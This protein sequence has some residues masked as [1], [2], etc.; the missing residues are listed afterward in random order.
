MIDYFKELG[1]EMDAY[2]DKVKNAYFNMTKKYPPEKYPDRYRV[3]RDAYETLIDNSKRDEYVLEIFDTRFKEI[4]NAGLD[5]AKSE[6][7]DL[8]IAN[9]EKVLEKYPEN[10]KVKKDLALCLMREK[11]YKRSSKVL[12]ELVLREPNNIEYYKLLM[13]SYLEG[14]EVKKLENVLIKGIRLKNAEVD[15]YLK[16]FDIYTDSEYRDYLKA[17]EILKD[18]IGNK[19]I[20]SQRYK[21]YLKL[22][23]IS[24]KLDCK[25]DFT[26][27]CSL[28]SQL[29]LSNDNYEDV[30]VKITELCYRILKEF[31]F[32]NGIKLTTT[33]LTLIDE[34]K[35]EIVLNE[36]IS[37]RRLFIELYELEYD[38]T[39][40]NDFKRPLY[41]S[42]INKF[43]GDD[44]EIREGFKKVY[45]NFLVSIDHDK[46]NLLDSIT[47]LK[48]NHKEIYGITK[49]FCND[50]LSVYSKA[51]KMESRTESIKGK[52]FGRREESKVK[53][54]IKK[55]LK[56][57]VD[58]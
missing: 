21:L 15:F 47:N 11:D 39:I 30:K 16:L 9:F 5:L 45:S 58:K 14:N 33:A 55:V 28:I 36:I 4:L 24:D 13:T 54:L 53:S 8:A 27:T 25:N 17:I 43:L 42:V 22:I 35:D 12:K 51:K 41:Y 10:I 57:I 50:I 52:D 37:L 3:I 38:E 40:E 6:K 18:G 56:G 31:H 19:N 2:E 34:N 7:Y 20:N 49:G 23:D 48:K 26:E 44:I 32:K 29:N 46:V 1:I